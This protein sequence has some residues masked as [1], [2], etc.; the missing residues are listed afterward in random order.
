[1]PSSL[2]PPASSRV[3]NVVGRS[4]AYVLGVQRRLTELQLACA[5]IAERQMTSMFELHRVG[6]EAGLRFTQVAADTFLAD[7]FLADTV[8]PEPRSP[9]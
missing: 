4:A 1:M 5:R 8:A 6:L 2:P 3:R 9:G 7:T